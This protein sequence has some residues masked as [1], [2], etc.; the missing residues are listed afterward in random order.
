MTTTIEPDPLGKL[1][2]K[3]RQVYDLLTDG[4]KPPEIAKRMRITRS[5][6]YGHMRQIR[7]LGITLPGESLNGGAAA[8]RPGAT[9]PTPSGVNNLIS[10]A[11]S[12]DPL[13]AIK[14]A[15]LKA[16]ERRAEI[17]QEVEQMS[18]RASQL[19]EERAGIEEQLGRYE[20]AAH[21][22]TA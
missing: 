1:T 8:T 2:P 11:G 22:L 5:G 3:P 16:S 17:D 9:P 7:K 20:R 18:Q 12:I 21:E 10:V 19:K 4:M 15:S 13:T 6:V 14:T